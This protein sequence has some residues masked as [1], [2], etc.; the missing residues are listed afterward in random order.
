MLGSGAGGTNRRILRDLC[1]DASCCADCGCDFVPHDARRG[2]FFGEVACAAGEQQLVLRLVLAREQQVGAVEG[3]CVHA[4]CEAW[5]HSPLG[6]EAEQDLLV[7]VLLVFAAVLGCGGGRHGGVAWVGDCGGRRV[8]VVVLV[9]K[10]TTEGD[11]SL[12]R[13]WRSDK[14]GELAT[15]REERG[16]GVAPSTVKVRGLAATQV[17]RQAESFVPRTSL[18]AQIP[19]LD[20]GATSPL[21]SALAAACPYPALPGN[22]LYAASRNHNSL[23]RTHGRLSIGRVRPRD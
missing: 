7:G 14:C 19:Q 17:P 12:S 11:S 5:W 13:V 3:Q 10:Y 18:P 1:C 9:R 8:C 23:H 21:P 22:S 20:V 16:P 4:R 6:A 15:M 2:R